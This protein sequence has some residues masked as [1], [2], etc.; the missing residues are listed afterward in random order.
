MT[1]SLKGLIINR[2]KYAWEY[3]IHRKRQLILAGNYVLPDSECIGKLA[4]Y[5]ALT[6]YF[7]ECINLYLNVIII[8]NI[9]KWSN[10]FFK[11]H[12]HCNITF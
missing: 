12:R 5:N 2:G 9:E 1:N 10:C 11:R 7:S 4:S 8:I 6:F 3:Y